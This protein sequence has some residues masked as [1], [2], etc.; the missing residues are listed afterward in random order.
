MTKTLAYYT[1]KFIIV[2]KSFMIK[3]HGAYVLT[4][5]LTFHCKLE[6]FYHCKLFPQML[7]DG[8]DL[9]IMYK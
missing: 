6:Q 2:M 4:N 7:W 5:S 8:V 3:A 1:E 9:I